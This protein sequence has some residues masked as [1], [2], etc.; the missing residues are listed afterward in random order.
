M[1]GIFFLLIISIPFFIICV[2]VKFILKKYK[3][4]FYRFFI[5][6]K[7][8][9]NDNAFMSNLSMGIFA[10]SIVALIVSTGVFTITIY[11][12]VAI[13]SFIAMIDYNFKKIK[14]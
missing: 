9:W 12:L 7:F 8:S 5:K 3:F 10:S 13:V 6:L 2:F 14:L 1:F 11:I 4:V